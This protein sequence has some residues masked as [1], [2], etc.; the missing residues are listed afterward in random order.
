MSTK[1]TFGLEWYS[2]RPLT[3][4]Q[5]DNLRALAEGLRSEEYQQGQGQLRL[6]DNFC[7]LG[8]GCDLYRKRTG[9]G[10]WSTAEMCDQDVFVA[11]GYDEDGEV[12]R[13]KLIQ[14][15]YGFKDHYGLSFCTVTG[16][17]MKTL[18]NLN[19]SGDWDFKRIAQLIEEEVINHPIHKEVVDGR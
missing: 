8:V 9:Q 2:P 1:L 4:E 3:L 12:V 17:T 18:V 14:D 7:C 16:L 15:Y 6:G 10:E 19:D 11:P 5:R 13:N